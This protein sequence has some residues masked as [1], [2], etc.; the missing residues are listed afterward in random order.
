GPGSAIQRQ[1][2][3]RGC[4]RYAGTKEA[5]GVLLRQPGGL[6][7]FLVIPEVFEEHRLALS[8]RDDLTG[9]DFRLDPGLP[10]RDARSNS[11]DYGL[12][13]PGGFLDHAVVAD[14][15]HKALKERACRVPA[16]E[17]GFGPTLGGSDHNFFID[18]THKVVEI[19]AVPE[20]VGLAHDLHVLLR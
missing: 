6:E 9:S 20:V 12:T 1:N 16:V 3:V 14:R 7:G 17:D 15:F 2:W 4:P 8:Q 18:Q 13:F 19:A 10:A 5:A 11:N